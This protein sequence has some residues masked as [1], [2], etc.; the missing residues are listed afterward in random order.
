MSSYQMT[1]GFDE[2]S[3]KN[4]LSAN[5]HTTENETIYYYKIGNENLNQLIDYISKVVSNPVVTEELLL[6]EI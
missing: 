6:K 5:A 1:P 2:F 3:K 4:F